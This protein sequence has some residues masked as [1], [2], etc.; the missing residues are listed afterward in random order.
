MS[1]N[2]SELGQQLIYVKYNVGGLFFDAFLKFTHT[3]TLT[4]T[5]HPIETGAAVSDHA[6][7]MPA[8]LTMDIGM[9]D[10][11][12]SI[13]P[14]QFGDLTSRSVSA[15]QALKQLQLQRIPVKVMTRLN[16]YDNMLVQ[17][18]VANEDNATA[19]GLKATV[20]MQEI[21]VATVQTVKISARPQITNSTNKGVVVPQKVDESGAH[22]MFGVVIPAR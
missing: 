12:T 6:Y 9:S 1:A 7:V 10:V 20:I 3:S 18:V 8:T 22:A 13:L 4:I 5:Q 2:L 21:F 19:H 11:A 15:Y 16:L 17:S 14:G